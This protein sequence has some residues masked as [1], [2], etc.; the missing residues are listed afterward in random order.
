MCRYDAE[1]FPRFSEARCVE[2][3]VREG[4]LLYLP[5]YW[6]HGVSGTGRNCILNW[7]FDMNVRKK[8]GARR[9][10]DCVPGGRLQR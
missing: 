2:V 10:A 6:W 8:E 7:W 3:E 9:G 5:I 4:E 1:A